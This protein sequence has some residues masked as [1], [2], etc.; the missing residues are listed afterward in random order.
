MIPNRGLWCVPTNVLP[1]NRVRPWAP[2]GQ[3]G[4][5]D[6]FL[7][8]H[9]Q[10]VPHAANSEPDFTH[11]MQETMWIMLLYLFFRSNYTRLLTLLFPCFVSSCDLHPSILV[12]SFWFTFHSLP[13][14]GSGTSSHS[15][16]GDE[17]PHIDA[18]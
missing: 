10:P 2:L 13:I 4:C 1:W 5:V 14:W 17:A 6:A 12:G 15:I 18:R 8:L 3:I 11:S 16:K 9:S 7:G